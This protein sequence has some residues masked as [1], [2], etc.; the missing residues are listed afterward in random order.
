MK[1]YCI[2]YDLDGEA[3]VIPATKRKAWDTFLAIPVDDE[4]KVPK[5]AE[6]IDS[7]LSIT[8]TR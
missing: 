8:L 4:R 1:Q 2:V 7:P 3:Y 5:W 6:R